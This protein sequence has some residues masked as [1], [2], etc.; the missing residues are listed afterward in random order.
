MFF[1]LSRSLPGQFSR[2]PIEAVRRRNGAVG[3]GARVLARQ[4]RSPRS[5]SRRGGLSSGTERDGTKEQTP[6]P[7]QGPA[8]IAQKK[9]KEC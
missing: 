1:S 9:V 5:P 8:S 7:L 2:L 4:M 3:E 6:A